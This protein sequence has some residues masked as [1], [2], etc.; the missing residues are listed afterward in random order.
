[1]NRTDRLYAITEQLRAAGDQ[2]RSSAWLARRFE[3]SARTIK[4]DIAAL[5]EAGAPVW[6]EEGRNGGYRLLQSASL[7]PVRFTAGEAAAVAIAL[8]AEP[9]L[10]FRLEGHRAL[11]KI[12]AAMDDP[13]RAAT[14]ALG[15]RIW[16][17]LPTESARPPTART[18]DEAL[19]DSL[20]VTID[21]RDAEGRR[22]RRRPVEPLAFARTNGHWYVLAYC[23]RRE[24]GRWFRLDRVTAAWLTRERFAPRDLTALFGPA[25]EDAQ[26]VAVDG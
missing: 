13:Q 20:V 14:A 1:M 10:P 11:T 21:Y 7:P 19:R 3:V 23:R 5:A 6:A 25:P 18:L 26:P 17:R 24:A 2:G 4:R 9:N 8:A 16:M 12:M 22:T 15:R